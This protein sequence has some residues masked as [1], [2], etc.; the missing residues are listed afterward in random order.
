MAGNYPDPSTWRMALDRDGSVFITVTSGQ[1]VTQLTSG[2]ILT[3]N[4]EGTAMANGSV[5]YPVPAGDA[6]YMAVI[7][8]ELRDI[9]AFLFMGNG[10]SSDAAQTL[11]FV[12]VSANT[13]NGVDGTWTTVATN[14]SSPAAG[15]GWRTTPTASTA[16][17]QRAIRFRGVGSGVLMYAR[18]LHL[19]GEPAPG[20]NPD[21]LAF[22]SPTADVKMPPATLDFGDTPRSSSADKTVRV[23]NLS[24]TKTAG[25][26]RVSYDI[27]TDGS[28]SVPAQFLLSFGGGAF[29]SQVNVG[30][31]APGAI[32]GAI[33]VRRVTPSNA[34]LGLFA[35][36][37]AAV[38]DTF[39]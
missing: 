14:Y 15:A 5:S 39:V 8:P 30:T 26:V 23:K 32:S 24:G 37:I 36:R 38:P 33:T 13:S 17:A 12:E 4:D 10:A 27:L 31:L 1:A 2:Q 18:L 16:L 21:R 9:D 19:Y 20:A 3:L 11:P 6:A 35:P 22:W 34:A 28:P 7:F 25:N 29:L